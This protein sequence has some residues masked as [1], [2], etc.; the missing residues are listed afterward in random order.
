MVVGMCVGVLLCSDGGDGVCCGGGVCGGWDVLGFIYVL[1]TL[2]C[3]YL[4][5]SGM[6][7][8]RMGGVGN[9]GWC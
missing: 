6:V 4:E 8:V 7:G 2:C 9:G 5:W 1:L 3:V